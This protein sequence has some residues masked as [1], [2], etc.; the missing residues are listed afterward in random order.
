MVLAVVGLLAGCNKGM[1]TPAS[2]GRQNQNRSLNLVM[3]MSKQDALRAMGTEP[4]KVATGPVA[5]ETIF[6]PYSTEAFRASNGDLI[7]I[8]YYAS[9][10]GSRIPLQQLRLNAMPLVFRNN[11]LIGWGDGALDSVK[12]SHSGASGVP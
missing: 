12:G 2:L 3:G 4:V 7:E 10:E 11:S 5:R 8:V 9:A 6:N 1:M